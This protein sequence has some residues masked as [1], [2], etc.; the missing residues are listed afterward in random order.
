MLRTFRDWCPE[1]KMQR[2][3]KRFAILMAVACALSEAQPPPQAT[4]EIDNARVRVWRVKLAPHERLPTRVYPGS[5]I[6][7]LTNAHQRLGG[8]SGSGPEIRRKAGETEYIEPGPRGEENVSDEPEEQVIIE[9]KPYTPHHP[10]AARGVDPVKL[11]PVKLDPIKLDPKYHTVD[12]EN[13]RVRVLRTVLEPH[14]KSP[15]HEHPAYVVVYL[16]ELHTTM[17][18]GD[19][20]VVDNIRRKGEIAWRGA[21]KHSTENMGNRTAMEIQVE[22]K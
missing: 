6:V 22:L 8:P 9:L 10:S 16:T 21:L 1:T 7:Y 19:G 14:I 4:I 20:K 3:L 2:L 11:D 18:S 13:D 15:M 12:F 17:A 5:V